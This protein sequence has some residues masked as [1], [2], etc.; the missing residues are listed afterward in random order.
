MNMESR[1]NDEAVWR[2][3]VKAYQNWIDAQ[4]DFF[5]PGTDR[6][7][8]IK[9]AL[10]RGEVDPAFALA[11][12][13]S[14]SEL[15]ALFSVLVEWAS[16]SHAYHETLVAI[17]RTLPR[18]WVVANIER[19]AESNLQNADYDEYMLLLSL[20][21]QLDIGI[22]RRLAQRAVGDPRSEIQELGLGIQE[23]IGTAED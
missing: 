22:T 15:E 14:P 4:A 20:Y 8:L 3:V 13:M 21:L 1:V 10:K 5:S 17:I 7:G 9:S 18:E 12:A 6:I 23:K 11:R 2:H 16:F 19:A